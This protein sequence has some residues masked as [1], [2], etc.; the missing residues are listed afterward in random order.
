MVKSAFQAAY[1]APLELAPLGYFKQGPPSVAAA[2]QLR[3]QRFRVYEPLY[4]T[5]RQEKAE[6]RVGAMQ[7]KPC[8]LLGNG[9]VVCRCKGGGSCNHGPVV[10]GKGCGGPDFDA[11]LL[12]KPRV[13]VVAVQNDATAFAG[14]V[15]ALEWT[16][17][18]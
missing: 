5:F 18:R 11:T 7:C 15:T 2:V 4:D 13:V 14:R 3:G 6:T 9:A 8:W 10:D 12:G 1:T 17:G 16:S